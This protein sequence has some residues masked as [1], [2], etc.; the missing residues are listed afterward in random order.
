M[1]FEPPVEL[2]H[3]IYLWLEDQ[4]SSSFVKDYEIMAIKIIC[5]LRFHQMTDDSDGCKDAFTLAVEFGL[6]AEKLRMS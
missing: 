6:R 2:S 1:Q 3:T 4:K 5:P